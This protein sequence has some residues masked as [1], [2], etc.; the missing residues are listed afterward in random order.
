MKRQDL[1]RHLRKHGCALLRE[2]RGHSVWVN[3]E[4]S[5]Q[6]AVPRHREIDEYTG[7]RSAGSCGLPPVP[8]I[9][10]GKGAV[11]FHQGDARVFP[12]STIAEIEAA[13]ELL[14]PHQ[15]E[16]L[17]IWLDSLRAAGETGVGRCL[18][19]PGA[20]SGAVQG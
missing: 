19:E 17:A 4:G 18:A 7:G 1:I 12:M 20:G 13:I 2:G 8:F 11:A 14:S 15:V 16:E 3:S 9:Q 6:S 10:V 5:R